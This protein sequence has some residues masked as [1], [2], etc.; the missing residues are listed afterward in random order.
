MNSSY[1][2]KEDVEKLDIKQIPKEHRDE[3]ADIPVEKWMEHWELNYKYS[4]MNYIINHGG[5][6][7][8]E[9]GME[10]PENYSKRLVHT[11]S[12]E[13]DQ[14]RDI[15]TDYLGNKCVVEEFCYIH[16]EP[17]TFSAS[18]GSDFKMFILENIMGAELDGTRV[19][20]TKR[21]ELAITIMERELINHE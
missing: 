9:D 2:Y 14:F 10:I 8:F 6:K 13:G 1:V 16:L 7:F 12:K 15:V 4:P 5:L 20:R 19:R 11:Y 18:I 17:T 21:P 3:F